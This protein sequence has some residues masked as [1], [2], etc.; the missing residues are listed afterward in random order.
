MYDF[1]TLFSEG[2]IIFGVLCE[3]RK[4]EGKVSRLRFK[5]PSSRGPKEKRCAIIN[6]QTQMTRMTRINGF[7][8]PSFKFKVP[9][10]QP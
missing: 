8:V 10:Q 4:G 3:K 5:V 7:K 9:S 2:K 6:F 1:W